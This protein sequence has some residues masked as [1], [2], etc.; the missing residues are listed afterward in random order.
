MEK[1][2]FESLKWIFDQAL[3]QEINGEYPWNNNLG[4]KVKFPDTIYHYTDLNGLLG[5]LL[6]KSLFAT[7]FSFLNDC[8]E[9]L[10]SKEVVNTFMKNSKEEYSS[11]FAKSLIHLTSLE[12]N[13]V[14]LDDTFITCFSRDKDLLSQWR[15]YSRNNQGVAI[16]FNMD[17]RNSLSPQVDMSY[18]IEYNKLK[19]LKILKELIQIS[20][21]TLSEL[22]DEY[23]ILQTEFRSLFSSTVSNMLREHLVLFK[24]ASFSEEKEYRITTRSKLKAIKYRANNKYI[25]PYTEFTFTK[26]NLLPI[27]EIVIGPTTNATLIEDGVRRLLESNGYINTKVIQ[28]KIPFRD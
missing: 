14:N 27:E 5:I 12:F 28:S 2:E 6:N 10:Y 8:R 15:G 13:S 9:L 4:A 11:A 20:F 1:A 21:E 25:I 24:D 7:H 26:R 22:K 3:R 17:L 19:Q 16:G 23:K 18:F